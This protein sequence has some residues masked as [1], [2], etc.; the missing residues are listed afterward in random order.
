MRESKMKSE[1]EREGDGKRE[2]VTEIKEKRYDAGE[3]KR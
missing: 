2:R 1:K 3:K